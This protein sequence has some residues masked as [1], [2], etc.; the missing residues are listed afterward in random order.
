V[1]PSVAA[2]RAGGNSGLGHVAGP[3]HGT[4]GRLMQTNRYLSLLNATHSLWDLQNNTLDT[5]T[6]ALS[7]ILCIYQLFHVLPTQG[8]E[9]KSPADGL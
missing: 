4:C 8:L 9:R 3:D 6:S 5:T 1:Y 2:K 7:G